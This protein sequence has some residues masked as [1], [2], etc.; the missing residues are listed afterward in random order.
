MAGKHCRVVM[1]AL[2][3]SRIVVED[4]KVV[5]ISRPQLKYCPLFNKLLK[6]EDIDEEAVRKNIEFRIKD[7]GFAT[8]NRVVRAPDYVTFGVS[9]ILSTAI[10]NGKLDAA[11][12]VAD[13]CGTAVVT[14]PAVVQG[15]CG[16]ISGVIETGPLDVVL[17][18]VGRDNVLDPATTPIDQVKGAAIA[19]KKV[20]GRFAVTVTCPGQAEEI[21]R[22]CGDRAL[23]VGVHTSSMSEQS[24][25]SMFEY[26]D[27]ITACAS[28]AL[29]EVAFSRD[30]ILIAGNKVQMFGVTDLG[31][32]LILEKLHS[33]GR[34]PWD[35]NLPTD[36]PY[37]WL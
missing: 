5:E 9:E 31:K 37:P 27:I 33:I 35:G 17:D 7:F 11:V 20:P 14:E 36:D 29:R 21:R 28:K 15:L 25:R 30:D 18:A 8:E 2:G 22:M 6:V 10:E 1:E 3:K 26:C 19:M 12:I 4:G 24:A 13:G 23:I 16:R 34:E 32:D